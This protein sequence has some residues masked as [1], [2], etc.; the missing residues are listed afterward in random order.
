MLEAA[1]ENLTSTLVVLLPV[2]AGGALT[3]AG[4]SWTHRLQTRADRQKRRSEKFEELVSAVYEQDHW[5]DSFRDSTAFG[6]KLTLQPPPLSKV[7]AI[8]TVYFPAFHLK[9]RTY[10]IG[11]LEFQSWAVGAARK[12]IRGELD[13]IIDGHQEANAKYIAGRDDFLE[14]LRDYADKEFGSKRRPTK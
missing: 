14:F 3:L 11:C 4:I 5:L 13:N 10:E 12:R 8:A 1:M 7:A 9:I 6:E 2:V